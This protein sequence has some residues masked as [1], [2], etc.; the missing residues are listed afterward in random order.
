MHFCAKVEAYDVDFSV[1]LQAADGAAKESV[2]AE[3]V[4]ITVEGGEVKSE[5]LAKADGVLRLRFD[6]TYSWARSKTV[7]YKIE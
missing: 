5:V 7:L 2:V 1:V 6:N 3:K 4:R